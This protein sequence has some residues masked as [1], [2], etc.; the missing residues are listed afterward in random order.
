MKFEGFRPGIS[1]NQKTKSRSRH[2]LIASFAFLEIKLL[3]YFLCK[4]LSESLSMSE[5][6][7]WGKNA[8][9]LLLTKLKSFKRKCSA[10]P[11]SYFMIET[12]FRILVIQKYKKQNN[13]TVSK[14]MKQI[15]FLFFYDL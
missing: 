1:R 15:L 3:T 10:Q 11:L 8:Q 12:K 6:E 13:Q 4:I 2:V 9:L 5:S 14:F 7:R